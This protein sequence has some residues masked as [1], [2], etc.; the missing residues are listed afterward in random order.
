MYTS[1]IDKYIYLNHY[2]HLKY[3]YEYKYNYTWN[4]IMYTNK[5]YKY[6]QIALVF[7]S[8][9]WQFGFWFSSLYGGFFPF[10]THLQSTMC[11]AIKPDPLKLSNFSTKKRYKTFQKSRLNL[12]RSILPVHGI[13][14]GNLFPEEK[15]KSFT[16]MY[17][18]LPKCTNNLNQIF[19]S[20]F[21][22]VYGIQG[23]SHLL[24]KVKIA[25]EMHVAPRIFHPL[26]S[27]VICFHPHSST[28]IHYNPP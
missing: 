8:P 1:K 12:W 27:T 28:F 24:Q 9:S 20:F 11:V 26:S 7:K 25:S 17:Q 2:K 14:I 21:L 22:L 5:T 15:Y 3:K 16:K 18:N 23:I 10:F 6:G 19:A 4:T 13:G